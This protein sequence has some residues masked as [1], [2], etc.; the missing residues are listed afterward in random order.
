MFR[1]YCYFIF[2][3]NPIKVLS[4]AY[5]QVV[6]HRGGVKRGIETGW[7]KILIEKRLEKEP[8]DHHIR[9]AYQTLVGEE[10]KAIQKKSI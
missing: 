4:R 8:D 2:Q 9:R 3:Q 1:N 10:P 5:H 6:K 7:I